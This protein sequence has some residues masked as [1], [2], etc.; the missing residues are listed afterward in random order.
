M[1]PSGKTVNGGLHS[2]QLLHIDD[3]SKLGL[4]IEVGLK[5]GIML[6]FALGH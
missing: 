6:W 4:G 2:T 5:I 3:N 1:T